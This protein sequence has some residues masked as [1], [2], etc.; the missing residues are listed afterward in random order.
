MKV[1]IL[2]TMINGF[3][4]KGYYNTQ[5]VGLG[6]ALARKGHEVII[7]KCMKKTD[8]AKEE[9]LRLEP[10]L[11]V[12]YLPIKG[13]GAHGYLKTS[14]LDK[15]FDGI[16]CFLDNQVFAPHI[17]RFCMKNNIRFVPYMGAAHSQYGGLHGA[18]MNLWFKSGTLRLIKKSRVIAKTE[19]AERE[20]HSHGVKDVTVAP[21]GLDEAVL[22][23]DFRDYDRD[24]LRHELGFAP[25]DVLLCDVCRLEDDKRPLDLLDIFYHIKDK[26]NFKLL[27]VGEGP[28]RP[29]MDRKIREYGITDR[30][31]IIDRVPYENMWKIYAASDYFI[32]LNKDE[33][34]GM[35]I[36]ESVYYETPVVAITS[37]GPSVTL[38]GM[39]GHCLCSDD[40]QVEAR[41]TEDY[42]S[43]EDLA[44]SSRKMIESF[45]WNKCA[46]TFIDIISGK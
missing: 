42:P 37:P 41:L 23:K 24:V 29:E 27:I 39:K 43:P 6:R 35:A 34:F 18:V 10:N 38:K 8:T 32:N 21:V 40:S 33:I 36:M 15:D 22:K 13:L 31:K 26:K 30:V 44:D 28:L 9:K 19:G 46:D 7:Y 11:T 5:E 17:Y 25:E 3:G 45:S 16:L 2:C 20:L 4:R 12:W 14:V 1:A